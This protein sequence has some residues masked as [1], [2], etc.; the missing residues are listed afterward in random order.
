MSITD[1]PI[2]PALIGRSTDLVAEFQG[3]GPWPAIDGLLALG[4]VA[5]LGV[6]ERLQ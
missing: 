1:G 5:E 6:I 4:T 3:G 2:V